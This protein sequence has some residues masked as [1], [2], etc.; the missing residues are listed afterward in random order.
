MLVASGTQPSESMA[1][2][3][4]VHVKSSI[5]PDGK[6]A[7]PRSASALFYAQTRQTEVS[8]MPYAMLEKKLPGRL[9]MPCW[10]RYEG[11]AGFWASP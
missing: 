4:P 7:W 8:T 3:S 10:C 11:G 9:E 1:V 2:A 5:V 6:E